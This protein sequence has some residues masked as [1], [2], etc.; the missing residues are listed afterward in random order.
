MINRFS[1]AAAWDT[2]GAEIAPVAI[3][4]AA[5]IPFA[6]NC[7]RLIAIVSDP[8]CVVVLQDRHGFARLEIVGIVL[9]LGSTGNPIFEIL[10]DFG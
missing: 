2:D 10:I 1:A 9:L 3:A 7:R 5:A 8:C 6:K 4:E